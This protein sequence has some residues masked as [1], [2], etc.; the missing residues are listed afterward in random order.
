MTGFAAAD[1]GSNIGGFVDCL[2]RR[3]TRKVY[4]VDTSYG[5]LAWRLRND[6]RVVVLE[7]TNALH[8][9]LPEPV[10]LVTVDVGWTPQARILPAARRLLAPGGRI[11]SLVKPQYE[12]DR[13]ELAH[14]FVRPDALERVL[15]RV[16]SAVR[17]LGFP[18]TRWIE[19]PLGGGERNR[20]FFVLL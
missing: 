15:D 10:D 18:E 13:E 16:R 19:C 5:T 14:G 3:G 7:R 2:L 4:S 1:L 11:L 20:E 9:E 12:A 8:V 17:D 6:E